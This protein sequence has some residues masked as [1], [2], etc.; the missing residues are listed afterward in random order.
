MT[1]YFTKLPNVV[2]LTEENLIT[3]TILYYN[4]HSQVLIIQKHKI[5][6]KL[7]RMEKVSKQR[8]ILQHQ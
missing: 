6:H 1:P 8:N 3:H 4:K 7:W 2:T 5:V